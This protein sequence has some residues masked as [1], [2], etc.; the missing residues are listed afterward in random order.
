MFIMTKDNYSDAYLLAL[1]HSIQELKESIAQMMQM[2]QNWIMNPPQCNQPPSRSIERDLGD[3]YDHPSKKHKPE[4]IVSK[5]ESD[6]EV[7]EEEA[8]ELGEIDSENKLD[9]KVEE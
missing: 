6:L 3:E 9:P 4:E 8:Y 7:E 1:E 2:M 5:D